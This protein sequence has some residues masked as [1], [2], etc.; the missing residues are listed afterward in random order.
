LPLNDLNPRRGKNFEHMPISVMS[1]IEEQILL[2]SQISK[3]PLLTYYERLSAIAADL[4][5]DRSRVALALETKSES[6]DACLSVGMP[7]IFIARHPRRRPCKVC[8]H[9]DNFDLIVV[10]IADRQRR[11]VESLTQRVP[12]ECCTVPSLSSII[13]LQVPCLDVDARRTRPLPP[14]TNPTIAS[15][16]VYKKLLR[17]RLTS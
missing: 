14:F 1:K 6:V 13:P 8:R 11:K 7:E 3:R 17:E 2:T 10:W 4:D 15:I 9:I 12:T 5:A 16:V